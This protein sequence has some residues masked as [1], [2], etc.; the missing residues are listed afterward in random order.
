MK[1]NRFIKYIFLSFTAAALT[2]ALLTGCGSSSGN[3]K[4]STGS[5]A[6]A[7][8]PRPESAG[9]QAE[10]EAPRPES[11][12]GQAEAEMTHPESAAET[13]P[14]EDFFST[15]SKFSA[16]EIE[17]IPFEEIEENQGEYGVT[18]L[19]E[20]AESG[21]RLYG[22]LDPENDYEGIYIIDDKN[23]VN[24]FPSIV[25][26]TEAG[27]PPVMEWDDGEKL[28]KIT[29]YTMDG[30]TQAEE[31]HTFKRQDSGLFVSLDEE[32]GDE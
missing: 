3:A 6:E 28:L 30:G 8:M 27:I 10:A 31:V 15:M 32:S 22:Y 1:K 20:D 26:L 17:A 24:A 14:E 29:V 12:G 13:E 9:G 7:E 4:E 21:L 11:T 5:Q 18:A 19:A 2:A 25:Y 23:I 16:G